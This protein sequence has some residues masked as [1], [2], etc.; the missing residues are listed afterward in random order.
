MPELSRSFF[1]AVDCNEML[2]LETVYPCAFRGRPHSLPVTVRSGLPVC[3]CTL[4][5]Y[6]PIGM[7]VSG[8]AKRLKIAH[9]WEI[10]DRDPKQ[11][12]I[13]AL[14]NPYPICPLAHVHVASCASK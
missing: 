1:R 14:T 9:L 4:E 13:L 6:N 11:A 5:S 12:S 3:V 8:I 2:S 7:R 10:P